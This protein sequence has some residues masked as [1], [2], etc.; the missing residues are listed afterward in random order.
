LFRRGDVWNESLI[1]ASSGSSGNPITFDAYGSGAKPDGILRGAGRSVGSGN[2]ERMEGS[3]AG[4][5]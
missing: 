2:G 1:P 5:L 3:I 4:D